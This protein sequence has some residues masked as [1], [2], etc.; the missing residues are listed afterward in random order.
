[1]LLL[2]AAAHFRSRARAAILAALC[3]ALAPGM[4]ATAGAESLEYAIKAAYL[5]KFGLFVTWPSTAFASPDSAIDLCVI[6]EDPFGATLDA[7]VSG[8]RVGGRPVVIRRL[9]TIGR[10][11]GCHILFV[12]GS[13]TQRTSQTLV[14]VRGSG[15]LTVTDAQASGA[16]GIV[17]FVIKDNRVRFDIDENA[18]AQNGLIISSKLLSLALN[19]K[20]RQ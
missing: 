3:I 18:A 5:Y 15:V 19:V 6:G 13:D 2:R 11:S 17:N 9:N 1:M 12:G 7:T 8:Q 10:D 16:T 20:Q 4:A 14:A